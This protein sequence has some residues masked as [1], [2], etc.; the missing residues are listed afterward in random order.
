VSG[1]SDE[2]A[3]RALSPGAARVVGTAD[4]I[5]VARRERHVAV[6]NVAVTNVAS[7]IAKRLCTVVPEQGGSVY[8]FYEVPNDHV[9]GAP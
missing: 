2:S 6:T 3:R 5:A 8:M 9:R 4:L 1:S 7:L